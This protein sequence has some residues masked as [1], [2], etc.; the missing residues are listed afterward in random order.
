MP[1]HGGALARAMPLNQ[2]SDDVVYVN[3]F[4]Y[5]GTQRVE[6]GQ[7]PSFRVAIFSFR[8]SINNRPSS[9]GHYDNAKRVVAGHAEQ[10]HPIGHH[11]V[12]Q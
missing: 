1:Y 8:S 4:F 7:K 5:D 6:E 3:E 2:P 10:P 9:F 12:I 11:L